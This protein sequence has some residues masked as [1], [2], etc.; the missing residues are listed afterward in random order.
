MHTRH[1]ALTDWVEGQL[2]A[3]QAVTEILEQAAD[4]TMQEAYQIQQAIIARR[5]ERGDRI[6]GYK[7]ALTSTGMQ[8]QVGIDEP[9]LGTLLSSRLQ[10]GDAPV[11]LQGFIRST[12]EPEV[13]VLLRTDLVGP[14]V[15]RL[16]ALAAI[17]GYFPC[18]EIGDIRSGEARRSVQQTIVCN[19]F[20]GGHV[21][22]QPLT[23]P[24]GLDLRLEGVVLRVNGDV[25]G[26]A[27]AVEVLG[28]PLNAVVFIANKLAELG[29]HLKAGMIL[30]TG[31]IVPSVV[32]RPGDDI[33]VQF[34]RLGQLQV[35]FAS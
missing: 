6:I 11:S 27:T 24:P 32:V 25:R 3:P 18:A 15:T 31:S 33:Q 5:V 28:D 22:G 34:T 21:F 14:G 9:L 7:A 26:S 23:P 2:A 1:V 13:G 4:L 30:M 19:T 29:L 8:Q 20:N 17:A 16:D 35:R 12:L 10:S